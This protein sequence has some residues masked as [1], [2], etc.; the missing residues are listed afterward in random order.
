[1]NYEEKYK[2]A[3]EKAKEFYALCEKCG[4]K[5]TVDFLEDSFSELKESEDEKVRK[6]I[7]EVAKTVVL[8]DGTLYGKKY[9]FRE[10]IAWLEKQGQKPAWSEE[11]ERI[12]TGII[13]DIQE[14]LEDYPTEQLADIYFEEIKWLKSIKE[15][16]GGTVFNG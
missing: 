6:E 12:V 15:I 4:A 11:D 8:R 14:R 16:M 7:L 5:D 10:W 9:N 2:E 1:M 3:L 13:N